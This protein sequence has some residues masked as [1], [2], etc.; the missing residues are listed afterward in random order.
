MLFWGPNSHKKWVSM[1]HAKKWKTIF[2]RNT[3]QNQ[4]TSFQ[5]LFILSKYHI[6]FGRVMNLFLFCVMKKL[7]SYSQLKQLCSCD[8]KLSCR[9]AANFYEKDQVLLRMWCMHITP[10]L[11]YC[12]SSPCI[13]LWGLIKVKL[14][15]VAKQEKRQLVEISKNTF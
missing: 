2:C 4:T 11:H 12:L 14:H 7:A 10:C 1:G 6:C 15:L 13:L 5:K 8:Y 3:Y 9:V